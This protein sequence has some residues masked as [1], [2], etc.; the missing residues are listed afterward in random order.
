MSTNSIIE[1]FEQLKEQMDDRY[2]PFDAELRNGKIAFI[3]SKTASVIAFCVAL[4][5]SLGLIWL[6]W[7]IS[8][9]R[10]SPASLDVSNPLLFG[11]I[12]GGIAL[13]I[14]A[15]GIFLIKAKPSYFEIDPQALQLIVYKYGWNDIPSRIPLDNIDYF[16]GYEYVCPQR[17]HP[18]DTALYAVTKDGAIHVII[19][20]GGNYE[21]TLAILGYV[22]HKTALSIRTETLHLGDLLIDHSIWRN[23]I[24]EKD[25]FDLS[26]IRAFAKVVYTP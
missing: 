21:T 13:A 16:L 22:C 12:I 9:G 23:G 26:M 15:W 11:V 17:T 3:P 10:I 25:R 24:S 18:D 19:S 20:S 6:S 2:S 5:V 8:T 4:A 1:L 14:I 7:M